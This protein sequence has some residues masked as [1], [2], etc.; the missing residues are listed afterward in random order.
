MAKWNEKLLPDGKGGF[1]VWKDW[2]SNDDFMHYHGAS[3]MGSVLAVGLF[4]FFLPVILLFIYPTNN[5]KS[6]ITDLIGIIISGLVLTIDYYNGGIFWYCTKEL[7]WFREF[8]AATCISLVIIASIML[9]FSNQIS[10][11]MEEGLP[12]ILLYCA[13]AAITKYFLHPIIH[14]LISGEYA[15]QFSPALISIGDLLKELGDHLFS[16]IL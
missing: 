2:N 8:W 11:L 4:Y 12:N 1:N 3:W 9:I 14:D 6:R 16:F 10:P 15:T 7:V 13:V 5:H